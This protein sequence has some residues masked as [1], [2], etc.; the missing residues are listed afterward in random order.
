MTTAKAFIPRIL[1][2]VTISQIRETF[3][4]KQIGKVSSINMHRRKNDKN[5]SYS[6]AFLEI[7]LYKT[8][9][10]TILCEEILDNGFAK[11]F[12]DQKNYWEIKSFIPKK[13]RVSKSSPT[14]SSS[15]SLDSL[16][17]I[18]T[19]EMEE[20]EIEDESY[21]IDMDLGEKV[22]LPTGL[23]DIDHKE[24]DYR[25]Q[26]SCNK[27]ED[28]SLSMDNYSKSKLINMYL[29]D[30]S[31]YEENT[32]LYY[33]QTICRELTKIPALFSSDNSEEEKTQ[34]YTDLEKCIMT[35]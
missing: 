18:N 20:Y 8:K 4:K 17:M 29:F 21:S 7:K 13:D 31:K 2:N 30:E 14:S 11:V 28:Y 22:F 9:E 5:H 24:N 6:F 15:V 27:Y 33:I 25:E 26:L 23:L 3:S 10:A 34:E 16:Y 1:A 35:A 12:Y 32:Y 19:E